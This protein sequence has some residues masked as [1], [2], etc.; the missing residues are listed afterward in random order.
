MGDSRSIGKFRFREEKL[1][2]VEEID[3]SAENKV[4]LLYAIGCLSFLGKS[5]VLF[6]CGVE[7]VNL[8]H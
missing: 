1:H 8:S 2:Y 4:L 3:P 7:W 6:I 5:Q